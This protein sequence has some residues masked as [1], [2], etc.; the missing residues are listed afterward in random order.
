[1]SKT[2]LT[3]GG[4]ER[5]SGRESQVDVTGRRVILGGRDLFVSRSIWIPRRDKGSSVQSS[6]DKR[7]LDG[8]RD[9]SLKEVSSPSETK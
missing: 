9:L 2:G 3:G 8:K 6:V 1:M 4:P 5:Q 7:R